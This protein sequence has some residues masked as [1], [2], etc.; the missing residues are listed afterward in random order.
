MSTRYFLI[1]GSEY[2][3]YDSSLDQPAAWNLDNSK[4]VIE[5][6]TGFTVTSYIQKFRDPS[7]FKSWR[8]LDENWPDWETQA[9]RDGELD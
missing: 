8:N 4:C 3:N 5:V 9:Q 1:T 7:D 6:P 2:S